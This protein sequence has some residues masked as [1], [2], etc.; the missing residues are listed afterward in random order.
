M[1][2][3]KDLKDFFDR[4]GY[5][6]V[7]VC[8]E[9]IAKQRA[10]DLNNSMTVNR[11]DYNQ[12]LYRAANYNPMPNDP[13]YQN[14]PHYMDFVNSAEYADRKKEFFDYCS[15]STGTIPLRPIYK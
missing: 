12:Q 4:L 5:L 2:E 10:A 11:Y 9:N 14:R 15:S 3:C 1:I 7:R 8:E 6:S 13:Y